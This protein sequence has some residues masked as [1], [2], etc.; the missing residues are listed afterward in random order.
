MIYEGTISYET[1]TKKG[2]TTTVKESYLIDNALTFH[3]AENTLYTY[4]QANGLKNLDVVSLKR[5][6][7]KEIA[8]HGGKLDTAIFIATL[9]DVFTDEEGKEKEMHYDIAF[10]APNIQEAHNFIIM[11]TEQG[12]CMEMRSLKQTKFIDI[13]DDFKIIDKEKQDE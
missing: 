7:I 13:L 5:S 3:D 2:N 10:F 12:Y 6:K 4:G 1:V 9:T 11:Y 8:R